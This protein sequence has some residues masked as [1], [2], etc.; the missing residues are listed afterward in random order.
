MYNCK[1][2]FHSRIKTPVP[3]GAEVIAPVTCKE[4]PGLSVPI[5]TLPPLDWIAKLYVVAVPSVL[6]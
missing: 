4:A 3:V 5:P 2:T 6:L 1:V